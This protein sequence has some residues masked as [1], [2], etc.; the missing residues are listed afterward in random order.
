MW[1]PDLKHW[2]N[3]R[4]SSFVAQAA[5]AVEV[6]TSLWQV[7]R[8]TVSLSFTVKDEDLQALRAWV[9]ANGV[10]LYILQVFYDEA[11]ALAFSRMELLIGSNAPAGRKVLA[12]VDRFTHKATYMIPLTEGVRLGH[13]PEPDVQGRVWK[14]PNG[15]VTV[16][17]RLEGSHI[18]VEDR[19]VLESLAAGRLG[20]EY[21]D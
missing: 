15:R 14:A 9:A 2:D 5:A 1:T 20:H 21:N 10:P 19:D 12:K 17:G 18:G 16:Y 6:E 4:C 7:A 13:V 3:E 8:S 11:H